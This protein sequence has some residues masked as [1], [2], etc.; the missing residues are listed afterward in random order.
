M[1]LDGQGVDA[2]LASRSARQCGLRVSALLHSG[3]N[4]VRSRTKFVRYEGAVTL[5]AGRPF[6]VLASMN[7]A[8]GA[9]LFKN[10][11][12]FQP[13]QKGV[14]CS[15]GVFRALRAFHSVQDFVAL[16]DSWSNLLLAS[17]VRRVVEI[18]NDVPILEMQLRREI[19]LGRHTRETSS[20]ASGSDERLTIRTCL[21][22]MAIAIAAAG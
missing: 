1:P 4:P 17:K 22:A 2:R 8:P 20:C 18:A 13:S 9:A 19:K 6:A 7:P 11:Q 5:P 12:L 16:V 3:N 14:C 10:V 21:T 15:M